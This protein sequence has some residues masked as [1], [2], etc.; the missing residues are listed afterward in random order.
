MRSLKL[1]S[2]SLRKKARGLRFVS[3]LGAG[4]PA[5]DESFIS[6]GF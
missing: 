4:L 6:R 5:S 1:E 2:R 3:G